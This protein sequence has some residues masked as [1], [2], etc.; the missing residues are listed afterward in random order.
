MIN[1]NGGGKYRR[2]QFELD[3]AGI[4]ALIRRVSAKW[5]E[6]HVNFEIKKKYRLRRSCNRFIEKLHKEK[7][8]L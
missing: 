4:T 8:N 7:C 5:Y 1:H 6:V 3:E 2:L